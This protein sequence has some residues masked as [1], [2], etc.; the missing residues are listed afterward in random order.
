MEDQENSPGP[1]TQIYRVEEFNTDLGSPGRTSS[2]INKQTHANTY[3]HIHTF[4]YI[5]IY[6]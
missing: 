5:Y 6:M 4:I 1:D 3:T 2:N